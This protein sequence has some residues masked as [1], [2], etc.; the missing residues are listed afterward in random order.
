MTSKHKIKTISSQISP[1]V[2]NNIIF[3][4][5]ICNKQYKNRS[6]LW[7]HNKVCNI[8]KNEATNEAINNSLDDTKILIDDTKILIDDTKILIATMKDLLHTY[9]EERTKI[10]ELVGKITNKLSSLS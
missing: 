8:I 10:L 3:T 5:N 7:R 9:Q 6:G 4:C 1:E 2:E